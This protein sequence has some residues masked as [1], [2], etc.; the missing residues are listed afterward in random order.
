MCTLLKI[1]EFFIITNEP[2]MQLSPI[3]TLLSI[4]LLLP[5]REFFPILTFLPIKIFSP[6]FT[7][8]IKL[9]ATLQILINLHLENRYQRWGKTFLILELQQTKHF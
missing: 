3:L 2:I 5:I 9:L 4:M 7:L 1:N 6:N 8:D